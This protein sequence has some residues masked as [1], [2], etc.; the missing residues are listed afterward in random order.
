MSPSQRRPRALAA[1]G[2]WKCSPAPPV[3]LRVYPFRAAGRQFSLGKSYSG[4][5][6]T[7]PWLVTVDEFANPDDLALGCSING[8]TVQDSRTSDLIFSVP[9]LIAELSG[10]VTLYP[11]D[12]IFTGTP[13]GVGMA[14][15]PPRFLSA[16]A[17]LETWIEGIGRMRNRITA[18]ATS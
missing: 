1:N 2:V 5:G 11:G 18:G 10:I 8:E 3:C 16:G 6:P 7:G 4:F 15:K 17:T 12:I 14:R 13:S 9:R